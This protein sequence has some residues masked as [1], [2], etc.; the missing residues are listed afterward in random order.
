MPR[1][2]INHRY[3]SGDFGPYAEGTE[4]ELTEEEAAWLDHDSP[5][6][7]ILVD[8]ASERDARQAADRAEMAKYERKVSPVTRTA[9]A[10]RGRP[11]KAG[12][13]S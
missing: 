3:N 1:Y 5:G 6:V 13:S 10:R 12:G 8:T 2:R 9:P 7:V 4:V 11:P